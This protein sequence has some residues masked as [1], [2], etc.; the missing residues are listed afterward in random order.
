MGLTMDMLKVMTSEGKIV[1]VGEG[2]WGAI[3]AD[4]LKHAG[5]KNIVRKCRQMGMTT[6][7]LARGFMAASEGKTCVVVAQRHNVADYMWNTVRGFIQNLLTPP[8]IKW[9]FTNRHA[10]G[11]EG[12]IPHQYQIFNSDRF[13]SGLGMKVDFVHF[14]EFAWWSRD[15]Q[16]TVWNSLMP[17]LSPDAEVI[18]ESSPQFGDS[19][20]FDDVWVGAEQYGFVR[21]FFPWWKN[22]ICVGAPIDPNTITLKEETMMVMNGLSLEQMGWRRKVLGDYKAM[23]GGDK[24]FKR[25][26]GENLI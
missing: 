2:H 25:E 14:Q 24:E 3:Y 5:R 26:Y 8:P 4:Y 15:D 9:T 12:C 6:F 23:F 13:H 22:P 21:H 17:C 1:S 18:I 16:E 11:L 10:F 19:G 7:A 20:K